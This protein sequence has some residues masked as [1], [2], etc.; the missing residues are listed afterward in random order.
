[1]GEGGGRRGAHLHQYRK[2]D[3]CP[4]APCD[5]AGAREWVVLLLE[6]HTRLIR[7]PSALCSGTGARG[8]SGVFTGEPYAVD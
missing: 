7:I 3:E 5:G 4:S 8:A 6:S 1:M 2:W